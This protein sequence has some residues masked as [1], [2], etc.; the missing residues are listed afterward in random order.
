MKIELCS[1]TGCTNPPQHTITPDDRE[2]I[3]LCDHH[4]LMVAEIVS[5]LLP[6]ED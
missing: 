5:A 3:V 2:T 4:N 1:I 6:E